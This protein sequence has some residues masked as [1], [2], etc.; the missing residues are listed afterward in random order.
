MLCRVICAPVQTVPRKHVLELGGK[1]QCNEVRANF[2]RYSVVNW[3]ELGTAF[4]HSC[5]SCPPSAPQSRPG[6][7]LATDCTDVPAPCPPGKFFSKLANSSIHRDSCVPCPAGT[8][9]P[10]TGRCVAFALLRSA[11]VSL[12]ASF[13]VHVLLP[14]LLIS[15]SCGNIYF[16]FQM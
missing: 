5:K 8:F 3:T 16:R 9:Q 13:E 15:C 12:L 6:S 4:C 1:H 10:S 7:T 11:G 2:W 14:M